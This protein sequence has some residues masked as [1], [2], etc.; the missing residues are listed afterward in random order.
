MKHAVPLDGTT[1][2]GGQDDIVA[3]ADREGVAVEGEED[4]ASEA[5]SRACHVGI[6]GVG[7]G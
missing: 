1:T 4:A 6:M 7:Y 2:A 3:T 5:V